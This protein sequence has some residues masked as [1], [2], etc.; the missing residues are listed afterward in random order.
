MCARFS[1][2]PSPGLMSAQPQTNAGK[3]ERTKSTD[4]VSV[5]AQPHDQGREISMSKKTGEV[6]G[7]DLPDN[8]PAL[9]ADIRRLSYMLARASIRGAAGPARQS[10]RPREAMR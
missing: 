9:R 3:P 4:F 10:Q 1:A 7:P 2:L 5:V 8:L 6:A